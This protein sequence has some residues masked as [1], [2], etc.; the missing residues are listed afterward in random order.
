MDLRGLFAD[1]DNVQEFQ[2]NSTI[3]VEGTPGNVMYVVLEGEV[4]LLVR[5]QV[6]EVAGPGD[7]VGEMAL[8]NAKPRSATA[9]AKSDCRWR[10]SMSGGF[11]SWC[12]S[13]RFSRCTSCESSQTDC[14]AWMPSG[15][16]PRAWSRCGDCPCLWPGAVAVQGRCEAS[17]AAGYTP[18]SIGG[19]PQTFRARQSH[20]ANVRHGHPIGIEQLCR[21]VAAIHCSKM[22]RC[23]GICTTSIIGTWWACQK[24]STL[25]LSTSLGPVHPFGVRR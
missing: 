12:T 8:I 14:V 24:P 2:A 4:E 16:V 3:F 9:R 6:L 17:R 7:I 1:A 25:W 11:S 22:C 20:I 19:G 13:I 21:L 23:A 5:S 15:S 18:I 10:R